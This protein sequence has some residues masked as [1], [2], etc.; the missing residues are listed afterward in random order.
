MNK[1]TF[2]TDIELAEAAQSLAKLVTAARSD[3]GLSLQQLEQATGVAKTTLYDL[4]H[5]VVRN[6]RP[7]VLAALAAP[8]GVPLAD[9]YAA[10]GYEAPK[11]LPTFSPYLRSKYK[12]LPPEARDELADAF[13]RITAKYGYSADGSGPAPGQDE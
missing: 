5:G 6:P 3:A 2:P 9:L 1:R 11:G 12:D 4:E 13:Q 7:A 10:A 8:L